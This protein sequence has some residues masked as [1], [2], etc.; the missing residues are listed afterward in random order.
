ML[1]CFAYAKGV[2]TRKEIVYMY[3]IADI[4]TY[5]LL[6]PITKFLKYA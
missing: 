4:K 2:F 6:V 1:S 3:W 5:I